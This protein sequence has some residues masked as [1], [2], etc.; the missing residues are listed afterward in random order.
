MVERVQ[1]LLAR[2]GLGS[3]R[4]IEAWIK[5]GRI[6]I[7]GTPVKLGDKASVNDRITIDGRGVASKRLYP[8]SPPQV[9]LYH[10]PTGE[11][12]SRRDPERRPTVFHSLPRPQQGRWISVGRLDVNTSGL[13]LL[14]T[15]GELAH[16]LMH[17]SAQLEREYAVRVFGTVAESTLKDL[18]KGVALEDGM[19]RFERILDA[20]GEGANHWYH[21]VLREGRKREVRRLWESQGI[22]VSRLIRI[23]F[24][25]VAMPRGLRAGHWRLLEPSACKVL[26]E[27]VGIESQP[28]NVR[29]GNK[30]MNRRSRLRR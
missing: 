6:R 5:A 21:V 15:E 26:L 18:Q 8:T 25:P 20:G 10:K 12:C 14:T 28:V 27:R 22:Q 23:R 17:P 4:E 16:R 2:G 19:A 11:I 1:K 30:P 9:L 7:N 29:S 13:L 3:R 24:G